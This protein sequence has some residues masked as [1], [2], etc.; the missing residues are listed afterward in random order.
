M[1]YR[2]PMPLFATLIYSV[3]ALL[4][5]AAAQHPG[6][7]EF[8]TGDDHFDRRWQALGDAD[9]GRALLAAEVRTVVDDLGHAWVVQRGW[10]ARVVPWTFWAGGAPR[11]LGT[12]GHL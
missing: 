1:S 4:A 12:L 7:V 8:D 6:L 11:F 3:W 2:R 10:I 9:F 5:L